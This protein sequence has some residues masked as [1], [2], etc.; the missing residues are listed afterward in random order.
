[1]AEKDTTEENENPP[2]NPEQEIV[3]KYVKSNFFRVIHADGAW[4]GV[5]PRGDI[6]I[7]F[8]NER[9]A[10]PESSSLVIAEGEIVKPEEYTTSSKF[11][12]E[13]EADIMVDLVTA[14]SLHTWLADKIEALESLI[15]DAQKEQKEAVKADDQK[16]A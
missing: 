10:I 5:S 7:A 9:V 8:Y 12:R 11:V 2:S 16:T 6:H 1:M 14:K 13:V 3:F 4:G 15:Q